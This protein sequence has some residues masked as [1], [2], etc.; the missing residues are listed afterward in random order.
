MRMLLGTMSLCS[1]LVTVLGQGH[2]ML[3]LVGSVS[4]LV[5]LVAVGSSMLVMD[6]GEVVVDTI[7][8]ETAVNESC[9]AICPMD[10]T[11]KL[12]GL[13]HASLL[14]S[15]L[16]FGLHLGFEGSILL[17]LLLNLATCRAC[18]LLVIRL[19]N[20]F[21]VVLVMF[22]G[23]LVTVLA[24]HLSVQVNTADLGSS[25]HEELLAVSTMNVA[26]MLVGSSQA[27]IVLLLKLLLVS[28][29]CLGVLLLLHLSLLS[30]KGLLSLG[31][32][33]LSCLLLFLVSDMSH[34]CASVSV[35]LVTSVLG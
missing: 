24:L 27:V 7:D 22:L 32:L 2:M 6:L 19:L 35:M 21:L 16:L 26:I 33:L 8:L 10:E 13:L 9:L 14:D 1:S 5:S 23:V 12:I 31:F 25:V 29:S 17:L 11:V 28:H 4:L 34:T 18:S 20:K 30:F 3:L 15:L